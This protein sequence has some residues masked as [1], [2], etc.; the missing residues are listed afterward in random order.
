M[1]PEKLMMKKK[2]PEILKKSSETYLEKWTKINFCI[3]ENKMSR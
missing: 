2:R 3:E 1:K